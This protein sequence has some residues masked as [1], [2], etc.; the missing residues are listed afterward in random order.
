MIRGRLRPPDGNTTIAALEKSVNDDCAALVIPQPN[1]SVCW[2]TSTRSRDW[3]HGKGLLAIACVNPTSLAL[4]KARVRGAR[5]APTSRS[6]TAAA[7]RAAFFRRTVLRLHGLQA[8]VRAPDAGPHH[9]RH[10]RQDGKRGYTLTLQA[11][12]QHIR[13]SK[14]TS[15]IC[16]NQGLLSRPRPFT[17][18]C[19]GRRLERVAASSHANT[20]D[21]VAA[22]PR[23]RVSRRCSRARCSTEAVVRLDQP[24]GRRAARHG[25]AGYPRRLQPHGRLP[26]ARPRRCWCAPPRPVPRPT[27]KN[28]CCNWSASSASGGSTHLRTKSIQLN[29]P[30]TGELSWPRSHSVA[31]PST[32]TATC[33]RS[34]PRRRTSSHHA[35]LG[36]VRSPDFKGKKKLL[37]IVAEPRH[38]GVRD[39]DQ[40]VQRSCQQAPERGDADHLRRP[41]VRHEP[42]LRRRDTDKVKSLSMMRDRHF[43][44]TTAC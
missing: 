35:D 5:R 24:A 17:W 19:S 10:G 42:L 4:L 32:P 21:L 18:R 38:P 20:N 1:S 26:G 7:R 39:V 27:S 23:S 33:P 11:R 6:A 36:D 9:W 12:E 40:E 14:A 44:R 13:R 2:K 29:P 3:A 28:M 30:P 41:A 15:N 8:G 16:T 22:S 31:T 37:N 25:G 43:A 34:V